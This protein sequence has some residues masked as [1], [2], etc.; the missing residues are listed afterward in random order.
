MST[1]K[2]F[3]TSGEPYRQDKRGYTTDPGAQSEFTAREAAE[4]IKDSPWVELDADG[5]LIMG[6]CR[7]RHEG[8]REVR[9]S[10]MAARLRKAR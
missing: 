5:D 3:F 8:H 1:Y 9:G 10:V 2:I 4:I 6:E 7:S